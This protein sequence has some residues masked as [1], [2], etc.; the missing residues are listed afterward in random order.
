MFE[1]LLS[2]I[3]TMTKAQTTVAEAV[4]VADA[5]AGVEEAPDA[6]DKGGKEVRK[7]LTV[8]SEDGQVVEVEDA[9]EILKALNERFDQTEGKIEK[10]FE[11]LLAFAKSQGV[12]IQALQEQVTKIS[13]EGRG[14]KAVVS[15]VSKEPIAKGGAAPQKDGVTSEVFMAKAMTAQKEGRLTSLEISMAESCINR[16]LQIPADIVSAVLHQ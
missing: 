9:T 3:E 8:T 15:V 7:S 13:G 6:K 11:G 2:E 5:K 1:K 10:A 14:R 16:G 12:Q 4:I